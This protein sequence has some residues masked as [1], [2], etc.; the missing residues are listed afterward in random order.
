MFLAPIRQTLVK[1]P[2]SLP[3]LGGLGS[4]FSRLYSRQAYTYTPASSS[5]SA[6]ANSSPSSQSNPPSHDLSNFNESVGSPSSSGALATSIDSSESNDNGNGNGGPTIPYMDD[7]YRGIAAEPFPDKVV[8]V[9]LEPVN[10]DDVEIKPDG[11]L[12]LPEIKYRRIL[13]RAFRPGGWALSPRG[14][15]AIYKSIISRE[16]AL[17]CLGRYVSQARG[18]QEFFDP[19]NLATAM[20][21]CKS[22]ALMRCCKDLGIASELWDPTFIRSFKEKFCDNVWV[23]HMTR[24][25]K[26]KVWK[27]KGQKLDYPYDE[28]K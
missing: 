28:S 1:P 27:K 12:Y 21:G 5:T 4:A 23:T 3:L 15:H 20:E 25:N 6:S 9:L 2:L 16:Y 10:P 24:K 19:K 17:F 14:P 26:L 22:N 13:N 11:I 18:E 7:P 8:D